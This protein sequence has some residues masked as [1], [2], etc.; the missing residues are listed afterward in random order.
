MLTLRPVIACAFV[1][2]LVTGLALCTG[3]AGAT[4][5][6]DPRDVYVSPFSGDLCF[7]RANADDTADL[8]VWS[9]DYGDARLV[10]VDGKSGQGIWATD[11]IP[12]MADTYLH[13]VDAATFLVGAADFTVR[14]YDSASARERWRAKVSDKPSKAAVAGGCVL[15]ETDDQK[16]IGLSLDNGSTVSCATKAQPGNW[17]ARDNERARQPF[18]VGGLTITPTTRAQGTPML[19]LSATRGKQAV[20]QTPLDVYSNIPYAPPGTLAYNDRSIFVGGRNVSSDISTSVI[21]VDAASGR[22]LWKA[23]FADLS[24]LAVNGGALYVA[25]GRLLMSLDPATGAE[26]W[27]AKLPGR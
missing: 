2:T 26:I 19:T 7:I 18:T 1:T 20:W 6:Q 24:F 27:R 25:T 10:A 11:A 4:S 22:V 8:L 21:G 14:S 13:C 16:K 9:G 5:T 12:H 23:G 17:R 15:I 3:E